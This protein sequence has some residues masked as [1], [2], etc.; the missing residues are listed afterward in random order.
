MAT[1]SSRSS[2]KTGRKTR[3][4]RASTPPFYVC[5]A[6]N[7]SGFRRPRHGSRQRCEFDDNGALTVDIHVSE[8]GNRRRTK[9]PDDL[10]VDVWHAAAPIDQPHSVVQFRTSKPAGQYKHPRVTVWTARYPRAS[11]AKHS[12]RP[13]ASH[14]RSE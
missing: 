3:V 1:S 5:E 7:D 6:G 8:R 9:E 13:D 2:L 14:E 4:G 12:D 11:P 10:S